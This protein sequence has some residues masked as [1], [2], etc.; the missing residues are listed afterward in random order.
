MPSLLQSDYSSSKV[1]LCAST[2]PS[3][4]AS[5][6]R[7]SSWCIVYLASKERE[8]CCRG[9]Q[10]N[11][12]RSRAQLPDSAAFVAPGELRQSVNHFLFLYF[13]GTV[14]LLRAG[15]WQ[16]APTPA[17]YHARHTKDKGQGSMA[18]GS[19][20]FSTLPHTQVKPRRIL[21]NTATKLYL[22][23]CHCTGAPSEMYSTAVITS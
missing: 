6:T 12:S 17:R 13:R 14:I 2:L 23:A 15:F 7:K 8:Y 3:V 1:M 10:A 22:P 11:A 18:I 5:L 4:K 21:L 20:G 19:T 9:E 16:V